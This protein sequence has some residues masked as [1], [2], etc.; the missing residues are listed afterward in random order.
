MLVEATCW[1]N[2]KWFGMVTGVNQANYVFVVG[3]KVVRG[4]TDDDGPVKSQIVSIE[5]F[6]VDNIK[7]VKL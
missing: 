6:H 4:N 2:L 3:L 1:T 5:V 7:P